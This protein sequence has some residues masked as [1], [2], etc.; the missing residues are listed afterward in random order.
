[1]VPVEGM[2][3]LRDPKSLSRT[4]YR[5]VGSG[6][7]NRRASTVPY[8]TFFLRLSHKKILSMHSTVQSQNGA[9]G[10]RLG[11]SQGAVGRPEHAL[12]K[13]GGGVCYSR[14]WR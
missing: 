2:R 14:H 5:L 12:C 10:G 11:E 13:S 6:T 4:R 8:G 1:M 9:G 7:M 3:K